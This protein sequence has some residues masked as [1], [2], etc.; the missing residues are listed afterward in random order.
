MRQ[1]SFDLARYFS[2]AYAI[3]VPDNGFREADIIDFIWEDENKD[4]EIIKNWLLTRCG[5][6]KGKISDIATEYEDY[7][8]YDGYFIDYFGDF[9][10]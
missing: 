2:S 7:W 8:E 9:N 5:A 1:V 3:Y 10:K 6:P 4:I